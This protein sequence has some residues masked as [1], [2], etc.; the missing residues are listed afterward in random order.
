MKP[1]TV[2]TVV[3][4]PVAE[5]YEHLAVLGNHEAFTDHMLIDWKLSG[6]ASGIG[7][8]A[9]VT[10]TLGGRKQPARFEVIAAEPPSRLKERS[11]AA[12]GKRV[13]TGEFRLADDGNGATKVDFTFAIERAPALENLVLPLMAPTLR[14]ANQKSL[15]RLAEQLAPA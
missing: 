13:G 7:A 1:I 15:D 4:R 8:I 10:S 14:K 2:S 6:P 5:V 12:G 9:D 11:T 3:A